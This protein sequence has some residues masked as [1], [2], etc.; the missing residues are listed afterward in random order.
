MRMKSF[1]K[2]CAVS[3]LAL[4]VLGGGLSEA[5]QPTKKRRATL[6]D[7]IFVGENNR[8]ERG[9]T[10]HLFRPRERDEVGPDRRFGQ[11]ARNKPAVVADADPEVDPGYG[12]GNL[13]YEAPRLA[14]VNAA[15]LAEPRPLD[16]AAAAVH[17]EL[18]GSGPAIQVRPETRDAVIAEYRK[19]GFRPVWLDAQALSARGQAVLQLLSDAD[20]EGLDPAAYLPAGL[21]SFKQPLPVH[22]QAAMARLDIDLF[23]ASLRYARDLSGGLF[24]PRKLSLYH[25]VVPRPVAPDQAARL[26]AWSPFVVEYL[27]SLQPAHPAYAAM[28]AA[29]AELR[30]AREPGAVTLIPDGPLVRPGSSD[31]RIPAVRAR[32]AERGFGDGVLPTGADPELLD[33][34]L[35]VQLR[36]FQTS[37]RIKVSGVLGPQTVAA[38]N[39]DLSRRKEAKLID[40]M[41]RLRWL[42]RELGRRYV[43]VNPPAFEAKIIEDG[44]AVWTTRVIVGK[45]NTQTTL[46][47]D[48]MEL[49][50]FNPS[51]GVP[52]SIIASEYL[53]KLR[54][55]PGYL[56]RLGFKVVNQQG[57]VVPSHSV[58]WASYG[59]KVPFGI[60]QPPGEKNALGDI[61]F[62]FPNTHNIYMHD[63]PNRDLFAEDVRAFSHGCVRVQNPREFAAVLLGWDAKAVDDHIATPKSETVRLKETIPVHITYFTAW[64]DADG[65][66]RYFEDIYGRDKAMEDARSTVSIARR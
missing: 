22:D 14:A 65:R 50:V 28:K 40:N 44:L 29:L 36:L 8:T 52:P 16:P 63:T 51:W 66:I 60:Q 45:P 18:T 23:A 31:A 35:S 43:F 21:T 6:F 53:P 4:G 33:E 10:R 32:L 38:L 34:N 5:E 15:T 25:D 61:K 30:T 19:R 56:D 26:V 62:L 47:H 57:K 59:S 3:V 48:E 9:L 55:D 42:P 20:K 7:Q 64:P 12:M 2:A 58:S 17:D 37:T 11:P 46:F 24:D 49:V 1:V 13:R 39:T 27:T 41:E 54:Q